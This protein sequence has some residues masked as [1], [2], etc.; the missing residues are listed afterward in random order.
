MLLACL[1]M[2]RKLQDL[3]ASDLLSLL[4]LFSPP[5]SQWMTRS[6]KERSSL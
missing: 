5:F 4:L 2:I 6:R 3:C 1:L